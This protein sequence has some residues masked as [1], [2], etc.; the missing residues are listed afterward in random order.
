[1]PIPVIAAAITAVASIGTSIYSTREQKKEQEKSLERQAE[2]ISTAEAKV[3]GA[4]VLAAQEAKDKLRKQ[5][6]AQTQTILTS[7]LGIS[8]NP[9]LGM[10]TLLGG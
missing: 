7:P 9:N 6:L 5:R 1:M 3:K 4:E 8:E 2:L 10:K